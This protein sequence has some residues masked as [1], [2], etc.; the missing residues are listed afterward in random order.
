MVTSMQLLVLCVYARSHA[1][2]VANAPIK[3][4]PHLYPS[5]AQIG[6]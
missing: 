5:R 3:V 1:Y 6:D 2:V 4:M